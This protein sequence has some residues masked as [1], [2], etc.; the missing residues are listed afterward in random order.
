MVDN[1]ND[2][3]TNLLHFIIYKKLDKLSQLLSIHRD[4][5]SLIHHQI[6]NIFFA[7]GRGHLNII[8]LLRSY[9]FAWNSDCVAN[10]AM[11]G[12]LDCLQY[13]LEN[14]CEYS[15]HAADEAAARGH[16]EILKFLHLF[17]CEIHTSAANEASANGH[18][19]CLQ[20]LVK[21]CNVQVNY[22]TTKSAFESKHFDCFTFLIFEAKCTFDINYLISNISLVDWNHKK[23]RKFM[24][25]FHTEYAHMDAEFDCYVSAIK[26][27]IKGETEGVIKY[28]DINEQ[29]IRFVLLEYI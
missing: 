17:G 4:Q 5:I 6:S 10:A 13:M 16:L 12:N 11:N 22:D 21:E 28:C 27:Q 15:W 19:E 18:L 2:F 7:A 26:A 24:F 9:G 1:V 25:L 14:G 29:V 3:E 23:L 20:F 8:K